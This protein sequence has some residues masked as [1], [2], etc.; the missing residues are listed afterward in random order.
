MTAVNPVKSTKD[1]TQEL[2][3]SIDL[4]EYYF[5]RYLKLCLCISHLITRPRTCTLNH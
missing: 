3:A 2:P 5:E 1:S 4:V